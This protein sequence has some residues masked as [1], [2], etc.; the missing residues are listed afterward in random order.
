MST[1]QSSAANQEAPLDIFGDLLWVSLVH[2][3]QQGGY[4]IL[5]DHTEPQC[6]PPLHRHSRED[7][8]FYILDGDYLF[9]VDGLQFTASAG[10]SATAP[11]GTAHTFQNIGTKTGRML[12]LAQPAGVESFL[13]S[14][15]APSSAWRSQICPLS[16]P[17]SKSRARNPWAA[18][19]RP[20]NSDNP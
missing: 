3:Y 10:S 14:R 7:E 20:A 6:G 2:A 18:A 11:R 17:S 19:R 4:V 16:F 12:V 13:P 15:P 1:K 9:K 5:E 8:A